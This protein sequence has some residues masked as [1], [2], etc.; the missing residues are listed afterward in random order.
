VIA[1]PIQLA[2]KIA[3]P[4]A[5]CATPY[6]VSVLGSH[7]HDTTDLRRRARGDV[8]EQ[9]RK[10]TAAEVSAEVEVDLHDVG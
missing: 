8:I 10:L 3:A 5:E 9:Q 7:A 4:A 1:Q 2:G 6:P